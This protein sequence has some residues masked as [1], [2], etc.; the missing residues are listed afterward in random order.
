[1]QITPSE[2]QIMERLWQHA[3]KTLTQLRR[4]LEEDTGWAKSTVATMLTR[5]E[6]KGAIRHQAGIGAKQY[7]PAVNR[8]EVVLAE[9][10]S[11][12]RQLYQGSVS[13]MMTA[14]VDSDRVS[15]EEIQELMNILQEAGDKKC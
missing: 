2:W 11:L 3:P 10:D 15:D 8:D 14:L 5:M 9:T 1:M 6:A 12:L 7:F 4:E 13:R